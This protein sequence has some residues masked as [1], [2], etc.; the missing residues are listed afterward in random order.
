MRIPVGLEP[1]GQFNALRWEPL[2]PLSPDC[3]GDVHVM[4]TNR[5]LGRL[6]L[7]ATEVSARFQREGIEYDPMAW[8]YA[9]RQLFRGRNAMEAATDIDNCERAI[10]MHALGLGL[11]ADPVLLDDLRSGDDAGSREGIVDAVLEAACH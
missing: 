3:S 10:L 8:M 5:Q 2:D 7:V 1:T 6:L 9:P 4:M 11:D